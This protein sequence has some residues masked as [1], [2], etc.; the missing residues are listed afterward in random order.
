M[1]GFSRCAMFSSF[2]KNRMLK[3]KG[4]RLISVNMTHFWFA[5]NVESICAV[6]YVSIDIRKSEYRI[7]E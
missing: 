7:I 6:E 3:R 1:V 5:Y 4:K 2:E